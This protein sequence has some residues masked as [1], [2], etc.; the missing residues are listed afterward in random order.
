VD[1]LFNEIDFPLNHVLITGL[2]FRPAQ[3]TF[4]DTHIS[5]HISGAKGR[6]PLKISH[7]VD[8]DQRLLMQ[9][10]LGMGLPPTIFNAWNSKIGQKFGILWLI[11]SG[12]VVGMAPNFPTWCVPLGAYNVRIWFWGSFSPKILGAKNVDFNYA[13][14]RLHCKYLQTGT[15][16]RR[17]ENSVATAVTPVH[18]YQIWW[19]L[20]HK[21]RKWNRFSTHSKS[22]FSD[23]HISGAKV[24]CRLKISQLVK[25][26]AYAYL[27]GD[28]SAP[29]N[30]Y[31][32]KYENWRKIWCSLAYIGGSL[33]EIA[34]NF[35]T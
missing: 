5:A 10:S 11:S 8:G 4:S 18:A 14:L 32:L 30:F 9:T 35:S 16:Y 3:S 13:I 23:A 15:R 20:V 19:T 27:I 12:S 21:W 24:R 25:D 33:G 34:P 31:R 26:N 7:L 29:N 22:T 2:W 28:W 1:L 17:P 6:C